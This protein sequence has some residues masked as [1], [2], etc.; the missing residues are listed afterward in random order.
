MPSKKGRLVA[1]RQTQLRHRTRHN[2]PHLT[3]VQLQGATENNEQITVLQD[4]PDKQ[5][6]EA[7]AG[8]NPAFGSPTPLGPRARTEQQVIALQAGP[9]MRVEL[10]RIGILSFVIGIMVVILRFATDLG[11]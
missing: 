7:S 5:S 10:M 9:A 8:T 11:T 3:S 1:S 4:N 6:K 2:G